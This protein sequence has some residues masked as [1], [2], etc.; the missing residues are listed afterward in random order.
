MHISQEHKSYCIVALETNNMSIAFCLD[1]NTIDGHA[2]E[3]KFSSIILSMLTVC[4]TK[5]TN[6]L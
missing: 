3:C 6:V 4:S 1:V 2:V 5:S